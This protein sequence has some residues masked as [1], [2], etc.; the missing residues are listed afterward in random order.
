MAT[1]T[2]LQRSGAR[3]AERI[4]IALCLSAVVLPVA[5]LLVLL[6]LLLRDAS[7]RLGWSFVTSYP[8]RHP[9]LA[10]I[11]PALAGSLS[12]VSLTALFALPVGVGA[13]IYLEEYAPRGRLAAWLELNIANLAGVPSLIYGLFGLA[14]FVRALDMG[15]SILAGAAT[16][17]LVVLP[18]VILSSREA[19]RA[20]PQALREA[21]QALGATR[22][23]MI[24]CV[25][26]PM[27]LPGM[28]TGA[29]LALA[30]ALGET[31][32][33]LVVGALAYVSFAPDGFAAPYTALP[34]QIFHWLV[35]PQQGF[36]INAAAAIVVL[37]L[38]MLL[39]SLLARVLRSR[40]QKRWG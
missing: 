24:S 2:N 32:P 21:C 23:R 35:R 37:L 26:L 11:L 19:L 25:L 34:L 38:C 6:A 16:L 28:L 13:A 10:G 1:A 17:S 12:L 36:V 30:R 7:T 31:A 15:R 8:S 4:F 22:W 20:V 5:A 39:L 40:L 29:I 14:V 33:L 27:A 9:E 3:L 18:M